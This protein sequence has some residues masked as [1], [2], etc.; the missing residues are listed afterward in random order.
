[1]VIAAGTIL[2][3]YAASSMF[4]RGGR[5]FF[6]AYTLECESQTEF[7]LPMTQ[8]PIFRSIRGSH[9]YPLTDYLIRKGYWS[10]VEK[11]EAA[12]LANHWNMQ[13]RDGQT[14]IHRQ[15][16]WRADRWIEWSEKHPD[17]AACVWPQVLQLLREDPEHG[18]RN[19][20]RLLIWA[21]QASTVNELDQ[22]VASDKE[23]S[24]AM[25]ITT[26]SVRVGE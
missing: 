26:P 25:G 18:Q 15:F 14:D 20:S 24:T 10:P 11:P 21:S 2:S 19:V 5:T 4:A 9:R 7:L 16:A 1:M 3:V 6:S 23:L 12:F 22:F 13:W 8:I 17:L